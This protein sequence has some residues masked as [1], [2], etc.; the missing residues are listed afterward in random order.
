M[1]LWTNMISQLIPPLFV[2][3]PYLA[4]ISTSVVFP[5]ARNLT[6]S[7][8]GR[9]FMRWTWDSEEVGTTA[10][11]FCSSSSKRPEMTKLAAAYC[12]FQYKKCC[13]HMFF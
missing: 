8:Q 11:V 7:E 5:P 4:S 6:D 3:L 12:D 2:T 1:K 13:T 10:Y 9:A